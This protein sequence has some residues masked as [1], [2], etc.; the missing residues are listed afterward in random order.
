MGEKK[1]LIAGGIAMGVM[2]LC[3]V[4]LLV[5]MSI[6]KKQASNGQ[7]Q[8]EITE[9]EDDETKG[10]TAEEKD[11][12]ERAETEI[13]RLRNNTTLIFP[14][15]KWFISSRSAMHMKKCITKAMIWR[16][17]LSSIIR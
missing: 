14:L 5:Q 6:L 15:M 8:Q 9:A 17:Y 1:Y 2:V 7:E 4:F 12:L 10:L 13:T 11:R 16:T 3:I